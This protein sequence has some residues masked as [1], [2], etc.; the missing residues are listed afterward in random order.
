MKDIIILTP[1]KHTCFG[2][3]CELDA[4]LDADVVILCK[5]T[6]KGLEPFALCLPHQVYIKKIDAAMTN[7]N[8]LSMNDIVA[9][10]ARSKE[11]IKVAE[12]K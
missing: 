5:N 6:G 4:P 8:G 11:Y 2:Y 12:K 7:M 1:V 9:I 10:P 3:K